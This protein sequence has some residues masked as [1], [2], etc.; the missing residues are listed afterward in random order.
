MTSY[1]IKTVLLS[2][3]ERL[4]MLIESK[5]GIP[6][7]W[8][9][10]YSMTQFRAKGL[11]VNTIEQN[12][13]HL[14]LLMLFLKNNYTEEINLDKRLKEGKILELHEIE[15]LC[16]TCK[17]QIKLLTH[18]TTSSS[19]KN[20]FKANSIEQFRAPNSTER[21]STVDSATTAHRIRAIREYLIWLSRI[22]LSKIDDFGLKTLSLNDSINM[23]HSSLTARI[24]RHSATSSLLNDKKGLSEN[25]IA[26]LF[27]VIDKNSHSNPWK[28]SFARTR[29]ELI[30]LWLYEFGLRR[31][32]LLSLKV[33]DIDFQSETFVVLR[34][35]D[36]PDDPRTSQP[37]VKTRERKIAIPKKLLDLTSDYVIGDRGTL[38]EAQYHEFLF[39]ADKS[40]KPMT[41]STLNKVFAK[42]K[43]TAK[44]L[45]S[46]LSP[47][48]L[49]HTWNDKFSAVMESKNIS[50]AKEKQ[51][52][53]YLMGWSNTSN[54]ADTYTKRY[55]QQEA[56]QTIL[57]MHDKNSAN[58]KE[59]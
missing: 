47:H 55:V 19:S 40:G 7:Y 52:R 14:M 15:T 32:E 22:F 34:R 20:T 58:T 17:L 6:D 45:P 23:L 41:I 25:E 38:S 51:M 36:D 33:S 13:R 27:S 42:L 35:P 28:S 30:I 29:N 56:N 21:I 3:G 1:H 59:K 12:L 57:K 39:V 50:E 37:L 46:D 8:I 24:P 48:T 54:S 9:T 44:D 16:D 4:P 31:G 53:S 26:R 10:I 43:E 11:A 18:K 5:T 2:T 49:R